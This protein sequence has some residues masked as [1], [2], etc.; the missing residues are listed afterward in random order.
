MVWE[1]LIKSHAR[2]MVIELGFW[3]YFGNREEH[4]KSKSQWISFLCYFLHG[5]CFLNGKVWRYWKALRI[6]KKWSFWLSEKSNKLTLNFFAVCLLY[7]GSESKWF[8]LA[9]DSLKC[10]SR[11]LSKLIETACWRCWTDWTHHL[12][13][14]AQTWNFSQHFNLN[15]F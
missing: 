9:W 3:V 13:H 2:V 5:K 10:T 7:F 8:W 4:G 11:L 12:L 1:S 14:A 15:N 6:A